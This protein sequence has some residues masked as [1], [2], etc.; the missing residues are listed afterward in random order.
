MRDSSLYEP[1]QDMKR[2]VRDAESR[3]CFR[4]SCCMVSPGLNDLVDDIQFLQDLGQD[5]MVQAG[6]DGQYVN[7]WGDA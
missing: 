1:G 7:D 2:S 3:A 4:V 6:L 5:C